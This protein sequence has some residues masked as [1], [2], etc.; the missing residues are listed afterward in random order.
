MVAVVRDGIVRHNR[1]AEA[2]DLDIVAVIGADGHAGIDHL[3]MVY[4][5]SLIFSSSSPSFGLQL[6]QAVS[7]GRDLLLDFL[8]LGSLAGVLLGLTHQGAD[9]LGQLIAVCAQVAGLADGGAVLGVKLDDL[10]YEGQLGVLN[11]F[12][13]FSLTASGFSRTKRMSNIVVLLYSIFAF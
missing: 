11:F 13:M 4:M 2:L 9:L 8:G 3:G 5:I 1:L 10:V 7:L 12:L 6:L